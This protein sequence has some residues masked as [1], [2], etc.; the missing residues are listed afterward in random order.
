MTM[1]IITRAQWGARPPRSVH[2]IA[3]PTPRLWVHHS[4][5]DRQGTAAVRAH[6]AF[7]MDHRG[8]SDIAYSFLIDADG[9]IFEGR[10]AGVAGG[11]TAGDN[12]RSHAICL[13]GNFEHRHPTPAA[14]D[15]L[16][17]LA[18]HGRDQGWWVPTLGGHR[19]APGASTACPG[20]HLHAALPLIRERVNTTRPPA[21]AAKP[22]AQEDD[23]DMWMVRLKGTPGH[24]LIAPGVFKNLGQTEIDTLRAAG[25]EVRREVDRATWDRLRS[26]LVEVDA[27]RA[28]DPHAILTWYAAAS[29]SPLHRIVR[30]VVRAELAAAGRA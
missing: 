1:K 10:G 2:K 16:V 5:D 30:D 19:D 26:I 4:A 27:G 18:R 13:L 21:P 22:P 12:T 15:A 28:P 11:H 9:R 3:L 7:H 29:D 6:Q 23:D 20:R 17:E 8:W 24:A 25:V 14:L